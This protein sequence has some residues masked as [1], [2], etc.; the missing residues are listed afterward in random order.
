M[1][2]LPEFTLPKNPDE[3]TIK[4]NLR[5]LYKTQFKANDPNHDSGSCISFKILMEMKDYLLLCIFLE[6]LLKLVF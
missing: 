2:E 6:N 5:D 1:K 4:K 3:Y